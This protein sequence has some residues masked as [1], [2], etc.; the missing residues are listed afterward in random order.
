[1]T[2]TARTIKTNSLTAAGTSALATDALGSSATLLLAQGSQGALAV[3]S[4][5]FSATLQF[6]AQSAGGTW[7][8]VPAV[9]IGTTAGALVSSA[10]AAG[11]FLLLAAGALQVRVRCSAFSSG[12]AVV[13]LSNAP[14]GGFNAPVTGAATGS[15]AAA[16]A[17]TAP[18]TLT[19]TPIGL[20]SVCQVAVTGTYTG[21]TF[22]FQGTVDGTNWQNLN[23]YPFQANTATV[24]GLTTSA[25]TGNWIVPCSGFAGVR[26]NV[27]AIASGSATFAIQAGPTAL[28]SRTDTQGNLQVALYD[29][30]TNTKMNSLAAASDTAANGN[31]ALFVIP[32]TQDYDDIGGTWNRRRNNTVVTAF[33]SAARTA[34]PTAV[35]ITNW[36]GRG[37][38]LFVDV[39]VAASA[40]ALTPSI[41]LRD[42]L[43]ATAFT[44]WA[45][46]AQITATGA[47]RYVY[48]LYPGSASAGSWTESVQIALPRQL[49]MNVTHANANSVTYSVTVHHIL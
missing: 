44:L 30:N 48:L 14:V 5:T 36:N 15:P 37:L 32:Y 2:L 17:L 13:E 46:A 3:I 24:N 19:L 45:A 39:T 23:G 9:P 27:T 42:T 34:T 4:G 11:N 47:A 49:T 43:G 12:P 16:G 40:L 8:A 33:A 7:F 1:M 35:N 31:Q 18:G 10:T 41:T 21:L 28:A 22:T 29:A 20:A 38:V 6:E 25:A 26:V